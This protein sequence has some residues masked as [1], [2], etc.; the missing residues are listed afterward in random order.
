[1][2]CVVVSTEEVEKAGSS[3]VVCMCVCVCVRGLDLVVFEL[4]ICLD[5]WDGGVVELG[6]APDERELGQEN[7]L[8]H[9]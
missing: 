7:V 9:L 8:R 1:M 4:E 6:L 2:D 3:I 5:F